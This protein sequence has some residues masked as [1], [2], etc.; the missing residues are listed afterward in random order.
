MTW[1][2]I[3]RFSIAHYIIHLNFKRI[4][5]LEIEYW[6]IKDFIQYYFLQLR[7]PFSFVDLFVYIFYKI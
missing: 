3:F 6:Q 2:F 5:W 4:D 1:N 7:S